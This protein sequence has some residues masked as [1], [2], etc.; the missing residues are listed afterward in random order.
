LNAGPTFAEP[1]LGL[2]TFFANG[3]PFARHRTVTDA[4]DGITPS[5]TIEST[6]APA[7]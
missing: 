3:Q 6:R 5:T 4:F 1:C 7:E 2:N